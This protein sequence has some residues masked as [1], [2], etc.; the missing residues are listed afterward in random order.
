MLYPAKIC[1]L[2]DRLPV[3]EVS[4]FIGSDKII[5]CGVT[6]PILYDDVQDHYFK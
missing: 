5:C 6:L 3:V 2:Y 1:H 4:I